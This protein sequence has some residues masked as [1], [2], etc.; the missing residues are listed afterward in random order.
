MESQVAWDTLV[1][2]ST[3]AGI[4]GLL[5]I[6]LVF[7]FIRPLEKSRI[8]W[9]IVTLLLGFN[10]ITLWTQYKSPAVSI[11]FPYPDRTLSLLGEIIVQG[12][13]AF[14]S[15]MKFIILVI[16]PKRK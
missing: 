10:T 14:L 16:T 12:G 9:I 11:W 3:I 5:G 1:M 4:I 6:G 15:L 13:F 2:W 7:F 8:F